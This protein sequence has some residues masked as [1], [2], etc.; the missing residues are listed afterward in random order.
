M[1]TALLKH[2]CT[3]VVKS[4]FD[5]GFYLVV[6]LIFI[7]SMEL[8]LICNIWIR[9]L[10]ARPYT[11]ATGNYFIQ[12]NN[13][14]QS[15]WDIIFEDYLVGHGLERMNVQF[16]LQYWI[17]K[18]ILG[19]SWQTSCC[20]KFVSDVFWWNGK[21]FTPSLVLASN[22]DALIDNMESPFIRLRGGHI[23]Y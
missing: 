3:K 4:W 12:M 16:H 13:N 9:Y 10:Y 17:R 20:F 2:A 15:H 19:L 22:F 6:T 23:P 5:K 21:W 14:A 18:K 8:W 1:N 7:C 11:S